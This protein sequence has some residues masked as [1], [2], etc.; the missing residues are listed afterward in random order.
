MKVSPLTRAG[1]LRFSWGTTILLLLK[2]TV[3]L[4]FSSPAMPVMKTIELG[5]FSGFLT[6][7]IRF[8]GYK[9]RA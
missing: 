6:S 4:L 3:F 9:S 8:Q 5:Q 1:S 7:S 2:S